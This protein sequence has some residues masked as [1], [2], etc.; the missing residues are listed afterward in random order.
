M[1]YLIPCSNKKEAWVQEGPGW[2]GHHLI[3]RT[4][5]T[6][7]DKVLDGFLGGEIG[8]ARPSADPDM[9]LQLYFGTSMWN[10]ADA[11][12]I[13]PIYTPSLKATPLAIL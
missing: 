12:V 11:G 13:Q 5:L 2:G 9:E 4:P 3:V 7:L 1:S 10:T 8:K 6:I